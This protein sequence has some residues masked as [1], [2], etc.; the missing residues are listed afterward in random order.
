[1]YK[2]FQLASLGITTVLVT[3]KST[4]TPVVSAVSGQRL[5]KFEPKDM[6]V[7]FIVQK[8]DMENI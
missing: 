7:T 6:S 3:G 4:Y 8:H 1:M 5:I 2:S